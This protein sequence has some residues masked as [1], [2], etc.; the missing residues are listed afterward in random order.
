MRCNLLIVTVVFAG[1]VAGP[2][3]EPERDG[4]DAMPAPREEIARIQL[5]QGEVVYYALP[6]TGEVAMLV[7][8][9]PDDQGRMTVLDEDLSPLE[10]YLA[11][12]AAEVPVPRA[13]VAAGDGSVPAGRVV[14]DELVVAVANELSIGG[15]TALAS[16]AQM[17]NEGTT[18]GSFHAQIC[19][20]NGWYDVTFCHNGTWHS[21]TD[22]WNDVYRSKSITLACNANG[23]IRHYYKFG[24][25]WYEVV[26]EAI[27]S[28][29]MW[30]WTYDG[31]IPLRRKITHSRTASGFVR[32][33]SWFW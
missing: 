14:A 18:S 4:E 21:V 17:C 11:L 16:N 13:L 10:A 3:D 8:S 32:G 28:G 27:P 20:L 5:A 19:S 30:Q 33:A 9:I 6:D 25:I 23:R 7:K 24:G 22:E 29:Q 15:T 1:C 26:D 31:N 2:E 12:T